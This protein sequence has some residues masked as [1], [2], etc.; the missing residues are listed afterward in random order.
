MKVT[1]ASSPALT[2]RLVYYLTVTAAAWF[3]PAVSAAQPETVDRIVVVVS[4]EVILASELAAQ[5]QLVALQTGRQPRT[6]SELV[7]FQKEVLE[8]MISDRLFLIEARKDTSI[9]I[10]P[11]EVDQALDDHVARISQNFDSEEEFLEALAVE[12]LTVRDLKKRYRE[13]VKNQTLKQRLIQKRLYDVSVS[14]HEVEEFYHRF[15]D[16]VPRQPEGVNLGHILLPFVPSSQVE[17]SVRDLAGQLRRQVLDGADMAA[18][19]SQYSSYGAGAEGGDLGFVSHGDVV[20]EF[21][22]AAFQLQVGDISGVVRTEFGYHVVRCEGQREDKLRLRHI[23]LAV[24]PSAADSAGTFR[25]ADSLLAEL[26]GGADFAELAKVFSADDDTRAQG[27]ELGWFATGALPPEFADTVT[28]WQTPGAHRGPVSS[29]F[30]LHILKLIDYQP[31]KEYTLEEDFDR[32]KEL[33]RQDKTDRMVS[34]WVE[35]IRE[36]TYIDYRLEP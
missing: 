27:G 7:A 11:E 9:S 2:R 36:R 31:E 18:L 32:I 17:D 23:L 6:E 30:G 21:A 8:N 20:P 24:D 33:A 12:G 15:G 4:N 35:Q 34:Q 29:R 10:R 25:L 19:A 22:R 14:R 5:T 26:A 13:D 1:K 28:G 16:S 3:W